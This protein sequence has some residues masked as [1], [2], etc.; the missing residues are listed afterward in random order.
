MKPP[1]EERGQYYGGTGSKVK[2]VG[3]TLCKVVEAGVRRRS[4]RTLLSLWFFLL[5]ESVEKF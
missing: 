1:V 4:H 5:K 2:K 3:E